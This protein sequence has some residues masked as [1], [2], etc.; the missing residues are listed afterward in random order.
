MFYVLDKCKRHPQNGMEKLLANR[1]R[2]GQTL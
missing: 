2:Q 1:L